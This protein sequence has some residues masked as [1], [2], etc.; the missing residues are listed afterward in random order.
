MPL[1][2]LPT[3]SASQYSMAFLLAMVLV[4][5][6]QGG[7]ILDEL[8]KIQARSDEQI[9][10]R[11]KT[12]FDA[13]MNAARAQ[14]AANAK[15]LSDWEESRQMLANS[16]YYAY[17]RYSRVLTSGLF[18]KA[19]VNVS[20][21]NQDGHNLN[22][23]LDRNDFMPAR[24]TAKPDFYIT[25]ANG[26][27]YAV[28]V[29][30]IYDGPAQA[31]II[32]WGAI[33]VDL[34]KLL[35]ERRLFKIIDPLTVHTEPGGANHIE[36]T[37][38]PQYIQYQAPNNPEFKQLSR[39]ME[40]GILQISL[41]VL[42]FLF[43]GFFLLQLL[44]I[45]PITGLS[46]HILELP[47]G[48][49]MPQ[50]HSPAWMIKLRELETIRSALHEHQHRVATLNEKLEQKNAKLWELAHLDS[51]TGAFNRRAFDEDMSKILSGELD[52]FTLTMLLIDCDHFKPINDTYGHEVGDAVIRG[53]AESLKR[54]LRSQDKLYRLGGDEFCTLLFDL[55]IV[56]AQHIAE[57]CQQE[58]AVHDFNQYG[59]REPVVV[60]IGLAYTLTEDFN[61][62]SEL[63]RQAD[64][65]MYQ[66]KR[67]GSHKIVAYNAEQQEI[68]TAILSN[69]EVSAVFEAI[70]TG[71]GMVLHFQPIVSLPA[72]ETDYFEALTRIETN[73]QLLG[74]NRI[75]PIIEMR[76]M[77]IEF[78]L[79]VINAI[80]QALAHEVLPPGTGVSINVS[81]L[82]LINSEV[83][84]RLMQ[85]K[86]WLKTHKIVVELTETAFITQMERA[87]GHLRE[88]RRAGFLIAL[89]DFGSGYSSLRYLADMPVDIVKFDLS[90]IQCLAEESRQQQLVEN[91]VRLLQNA[92]YSLVAE[93]IENELLLEKVTQLGFSHA[94]GFY[95]GTPE[96]TAHM[97]LDLPAHSPT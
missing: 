12:D 39:L 74:P 2:K 7:F 84:A 59:V 69:P 9:Q 79:A 72:K 81:G 95:L 35:A 49:P 63:S 65:A 11:A 58:V 96:K 91:L 24:V 13:G 48:T 44:I 28:Q 90:L 6:I 25:A 68:S 18:D 17:W 86:S 71:K 52:S 8:R 57:R 22:P 66:A 92:N 87:T 80:G 41:I 36:W 30:P 4:V 88:L 43:L 15:A 67:P 61:S 78:D 27:P 38:T 77:E 50:H 51:L 75:F 60:S 70:K 40:R 37:Q 94:Q 73:D 3:F 55:D 34:V 62:L 14:I 82:S 19:V 85:L 32:G 54:A 20:L 45:R 33:R 46:R 5:V 97:S 83:I 23:I 10:E 16:T 1:K 26:R 31:R 47:S 21:Y 42:A 89:D 56:V 93:G 64:I 76:R 53:I 29:T